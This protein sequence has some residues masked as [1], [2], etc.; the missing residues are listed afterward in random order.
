M[1]CLKGDLDLQETVMPLLNE[2]LSIWEIGFRWAGYDPHSFWL[3][4]PQPVRD[5]FRTLI[6]EIYES[7]LE[8]HTLQTA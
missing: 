3:R 7:R 1:L 6:Q 2:Q 4:I 8:C 5:R